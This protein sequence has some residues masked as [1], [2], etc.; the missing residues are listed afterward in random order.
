MKHLKKFE[1]LQFPKIGDYIYV[2]VE[3]DFNL[4]PREKKRC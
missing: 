2:N 1:D 4:E 3:S